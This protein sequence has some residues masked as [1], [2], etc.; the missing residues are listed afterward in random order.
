MKQP[1]DE[2]APSGARTT[3]E[4]QSFADRLFIGPEGL[5]ALWRLAI[6]VAAFYFVE[7]GLAFLLAP[8]FDQIPDNSMRLPYLL[9]ISDC[10]GLVA[11]LLPA[12]AMAKFEERPFSVYGLP[13][14][15]DSAKNFWAGTVWGIVSLAL[16]LALMHAFGAFHL[17]AISLHGGRM[18][19]FAAFWGFTFLVVAF[20]EEFFTRGYLQ[21]TLTDGIGFWPAAA[22]LSVVFGAEHLLN[23]GE[24]WRGALGAGIIGLFWC[25]TLRRTGTLWFGIGMHAAWDWSETF[26][27]AVPDSGIVAPGHLFN[28][29]FDGSRWLTGGTVGPEGSVL[30]L[31]V[32]AL[33]WAVFDWLYPEVK[34]KVA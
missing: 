1:T 2:D 6:Y 9:L 8:L 30:V 12:L 18:L 16:L 15:K 26:L 23:P 13:A 33:L 10:I 4:A 17:G 21:F 31:V 5:R 3:N 29:T 34:Y 14:A 22:A 19:K 7:Y 28:S 24:N 25:F 27:Y 20:Y 32:V 11:A